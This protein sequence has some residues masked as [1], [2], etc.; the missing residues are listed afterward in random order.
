MKRVKAA[1]IC[2][3]LLFTSKEGPGNAGDLVRQE[4]AQYKRRLDS[5]RTQYR[6]VEE[7]QLPDGSIQMDIIKQYNGS[8]VGDYLNR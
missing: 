2:Q 4:A 8:P 6:I 1:C 3:T 7:R 5:N